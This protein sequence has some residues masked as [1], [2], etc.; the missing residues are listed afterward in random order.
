M[1]CKLDSS[2]EYLQTLSWSHKK[3]KLCLS[4]IPFLLTLQLDLSPVLWLIL[5]DR[6]PA[7]R[8]SWK[9]R[10][11]EGK[12]VHPRKKLSSKSARAMPFSQEEDVLLLLGSREVCGGKV[13]LLYVS[14][15]RQV[16]DE[17]YHHPHIHAGAYSDR[18]GSEEQSPSGGNVG[19]WEVTFVHCLGGL[20]RRKCKRRRRKS[21]TVWRDLKR[22]SDLF[23]K[24]TIITE[25]VLYFC[26]DVRK[27]KGMHTLHDG[28]IDQETQC[29]PGES[30]S[31]MTGLKNGNQLSRTRGYS[32]I[33]S[34]Q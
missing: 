21:D 14:W 31:C 5:A 20:E 7:G 16:G 11:V 24:R 8:E 2:M 22:K 10:K 29:N 19:Q 30:S 3:Q 18:E 17:S 12:T 25:A 4:P 13:R 6:G 9:E 32:H 23:F 1:G 27:K 34:Q 15:F 28:P 26:G 33:S